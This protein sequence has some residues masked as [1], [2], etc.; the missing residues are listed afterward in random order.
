[1]K[2]HYKDVLEDLQAL[3]KL[4]QYQPVIIGTPPLGIQI[5]TSDIDIACSSIN[6]EDF[7]RATVKIFGDFNGFST[8]TRFVQHRPTVI[9]N[10]KH[11]GWEIEIFCQTIPTI[12]Q[13]GVRHYFVEKRLLDLA[14]DLASQI[15]A[16]KQQGLKTEPAFAKTLGLTGDPYEVILELENR[17]DY[18]LLNLLSECVLGKN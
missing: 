10:F 5:E 4:S 14:P 7:E 6:L 3:E 18:E 17:S 1:M 2:P 12:D 11:M 16:L 15:R 8:R 13:W 9:V